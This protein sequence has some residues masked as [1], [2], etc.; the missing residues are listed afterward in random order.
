MAIPR[1]AALARNDRDYFSI[2]VAPCALASDTRAI[3]YDVSA[4][5]TRSRALLSDIDAVITSAFPLTP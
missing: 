2:A 5:M 1:L 3:W 4:S